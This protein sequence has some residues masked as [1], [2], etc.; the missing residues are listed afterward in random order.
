MLLGLSLEVHV[1]A[2]VSKDALHRIGTAFAPQG[3]DTTGMEDADAVEYAFS[4]PDAIAALTSLGVTWST[5]RTG[6]VSEE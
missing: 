3:M 5:I 2:D 4:D 6:R 1:P